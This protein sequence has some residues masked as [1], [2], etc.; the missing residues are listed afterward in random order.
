[1]KATP[2]IPPLATLIYLSA[3]S[4]RLPI[5]SAEEHFDTCVLALPLELVLGLF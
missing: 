4:K 1:M 5:G 3:N 2:A